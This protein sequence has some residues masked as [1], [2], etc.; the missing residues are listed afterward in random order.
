[1]SNGWAKPNRFV[2]K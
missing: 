2:L 1:M